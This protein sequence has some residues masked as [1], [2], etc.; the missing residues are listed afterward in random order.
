[1]VAP[2]QHVGVAVS[3][4]VDSV[5]LLHLLRE[6]SVGPLTV[7]HLDHQ[8]RGEESR[9]DAEF[10]AAMAAQ[11]G[12]PLIAHAAELSA[13]NLEE[14]GR[15]A[16]LAFFRH[17][18]SS[19]A[20]DKVATGHTK[21]DQAETVLFRILRG[22]GTLGLAAIRPATSDGL[23]R[24][25]IDI[26]RQEVRRY[27]A[28]RGV[29]W[30]EDST[31]AG[32]QFARSRIRHELLPQLERE[33]NPGVID[34]LARTADC[35]L[36]EE[37]YWR[38]E[39]DR[40]EGRALTVDRGAVLLDTG[41][42]CDLPLAVARRL[43]RRAVERTKGD[44]RGVGFNHIDDVVR[45][46]GSD[47]G[48][49]R[50]ALPGF[51]VL[52][53]FGTLRFS[54]RGD[55]SAAAPFRIGAPVPGFIPI[56]GTGRAIC[57]ELIEKTTG[58]DDPEYVYNGGMGRVNWDRVSNS[59]VLRSWMPGDRYQPFQSAH[60][61]KL[62]TL[63]QH[64]RIPSWDRS[65]WPVLASGDAIVWTRRFGTA[66]AFAAGPATRTILTVRETDAA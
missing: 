53:S 11:M 6:L 10:V 64:A 5:C 42:L 27:L 35:A 45:L 65:N 24:P 23:I 46:A 13:G 18:I 55:S 9:R 8:L 32:R 20:V 36:A 21:S 57:L 19:G 25:L 58:F 62:K 61:S 17:A 12:L 43:V 50:I 47:R 54:A 49:G 60:I 3:G 2:G 7:L 63:F 34:A 52:R 29:E 56:P 22:A 44:V 41:V 15:E 48:T 31:N 37:E 38:T 1:M 26:D 16:R 4:G 39:L 66:A 28:G 14:A 33:W 30:R 40:L 51:G 59:L